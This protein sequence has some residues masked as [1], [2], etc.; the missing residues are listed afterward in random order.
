[1]VVAMA[2]FPKTL[3]YSFGMRPPG[4]KRILGPGPGSYEQ[5]Y[6]PAGPSHSLHGRLHV[7]Q[8]GQRS[9][10]GPG[11]YNV[12]PKHDG[13][14]FTLHSRTGGG[15]W[16]SQTPG[17]GAYDPSRRYVSNASPKF[18]LG[19]RLSSYYYQHEQEWRPGPGSYSPALPPD[20]PA[21][22]MHCRF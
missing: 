13:P 22:S 10:P 12:V 2:E 11:T 16:Q 5:I 14:A 21:F 20:G 8:Y 1:M 19:Q 7:R 15:H 17:P 9:V 4:S 18:S 3:S 6:K